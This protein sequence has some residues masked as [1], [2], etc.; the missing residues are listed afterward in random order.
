VV[1]VLLLGLLFLVLVGAALVIVPKVALHL[2]DGLGAAP[3]QDDPWTARL[4]VWF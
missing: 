3:V 1:I 4:R 2:V